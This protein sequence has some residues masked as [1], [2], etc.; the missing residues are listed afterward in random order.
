MCNVRALVDLPAVYTYEFLRYELL[1]YELLMY[2]WL[3]Y[4][5]LNVESAVRRSKTSAD[6]Q[7]KEMPREK[8]RKK[9]TSQAQAS[10]SRRP[11]SLS[12]I[13]AELHYG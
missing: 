6:D 5:L 2:E 10:A 13:L 1:M 11:S 4:E 8:K 7:K 9:L 12:H 3:R